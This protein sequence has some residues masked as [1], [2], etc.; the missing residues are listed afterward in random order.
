MLVNFLRV[1]VYCVHVV[2]QTVAMFP[3]HFTCS[4]KPLFRDFYC[5]ILLILEQCVRAH[6]QTFEPI[7]WNSSL[8]K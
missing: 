6:N 7:Y 2:A 5:L 3:L 4:N 1:F 8:L